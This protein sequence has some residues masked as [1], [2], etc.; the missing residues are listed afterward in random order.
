M[1]LANR[2]PSHAVIEALDIQPLDRVLD[3]GCGDGSMIAAMPAAA[4]TCGLDSSATMIDAA[5]VRNRDAVISGRVSFLHGDMMALPFPPKSFD[6]IAASNV[7]YFCADVPALIHECRRVSTPGA[8]LVI[9]VTSAESMRRWRFASYATHRHFTPLQLEQEL[10]RAGV[11]SDI[12]R[13]DRL[14]LPGGIEGLVA[15]VNLDPPRINGKLGNARVIS[16]K[17]VRE[18]SV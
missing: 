4:H 1:R 18:T 10:A 11:S 5:R 2:Q 16:K 14:S 15:R 12:L 8:T 9:Y 7:L 6:K 13:I 17:P 3:I